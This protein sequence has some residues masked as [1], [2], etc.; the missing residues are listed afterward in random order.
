MRIAVHTR[1]G[2]TMWMLWLHVALLCATLVV[3]GI[4]TR[5]AVQVVSCMRGHLDMLMGKPWCHGRCG[6]LVFG[7]VHGVSH[8]Y[9]CRQDKNT[10]WLHSHCL[11]ALRS[12]C[13]KNHFQVN[14]TD[15]AQ[16]GQESEQVGQVS[17]HLFSSVPGMRNLNGGCG[18]HWLPWTTRS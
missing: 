16:V 10:T 14:P 4:M 7:A 11:I 3:V 9:R 2:G 13:Q 12:C 18:A 1:W 8:A 17:L 15:W 5:C 6:R